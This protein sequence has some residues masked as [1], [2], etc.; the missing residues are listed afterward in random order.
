VP[1]QALSANWNIAARRNAISQRPDWPTT[2]HWV[3]GSYDCTT[4]KVASQSIVDFTFNLGTGR[5]Q[6]STLRRRVNQRD[7]ISA[8]A[9]LGRWVRGGGQ[10]L[11]GLEPDILALMPFRPA[12]DGPRTMDLAIF[13]PGPMGLRERMLGIHIEDRLNYHSASNTVYMNFSGMRVRDEADIK[14][15]VDAVDTLLGGLGKRVHSVVNYERFSCDDDVFAQYIDAVKYV[16]ETYYIDVKRYTSGAF[17][18]HKLGSELAKREISFEV[19]GSN[20]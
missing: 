2:R 3:A 1:F 14:M 20:D 17:L 18:R 11:P 4:Q 6:T 10:V 15:I 13:Q 16:E 12:I 8:A 19:L 7:W 9:E 5:L